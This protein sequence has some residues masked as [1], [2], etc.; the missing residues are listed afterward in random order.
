LPRSFESLDSWL[1]EF[2]GLAQPG[3]PVIIVGNKLDLYVNG[4]GNCVRPKEGE[5]WA[6]QRGLKY[7]STCAYDGTGLTELVDYLTS[8]IP[9]R[10]FSY[11]PSSIQ[12]DGDRPQQ[13][14]KKTLECCT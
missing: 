5:K 1:A 7:F 3:A 10:Q 9:P 12:L 4:D 2:T 14:T 6:R 8:A 13:S 11:Y